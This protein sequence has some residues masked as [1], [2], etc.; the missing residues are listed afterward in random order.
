MNPESDQEVGSLKLNSLHA[1]LDSFGLK[2]LL[3][4]IPTKATLESL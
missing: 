2:F 1:S 3:F 4:K